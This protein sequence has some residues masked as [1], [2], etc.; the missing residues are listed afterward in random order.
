MSRPAAASS[1][2][3][4][5]A[6]Q[7]WLPAGLVLIALLVAAV[8]SLGAPLITSV[9]ASYDVSL[10]AAQWTLTV[11][12]LSGAVCTPLL[13]RLGT[14]RRR[15]TATLATLTV[16]TA[17]SVGTVLSGPFALLVAGRAA[18]GVG[19]GLVPL[20]M[21]TARDSLDERRATSVIAM[22]SVATTAAIGVGYPLT[23]FLA[24]IGG[25]R[26]AYAAGLVAT[27]AALLV[28]V[29]V[30]P[31]PDAGAGRP[32]RVDWAGAVLLGLALIAVL[33]PLG[34][35][36]LWHRQAAVALLLLGAGV[37][38]LLV[39]L[40]VERRVAAPL[41]DL[42][43]LRHPMV[44]R[45][46]LAM[47]VGGAAMY[48]LLTLATRYVQTPAAAG[49]GF[50]LDTFEAGLVLVPFS[51][52]GFVAGRM[53]PRLV[54]RINAARTVAASLVVVALGFVV[55]VVGRSTVAGPVVA[56][57]VLGLG[58]GAVSAA[59]PA[60][61]LASTPTGQTAGAMS[62]NQVVRSVG[63]AVGSALGG[64]ILSAST[65]AGGFPERS[66]YVAA[67][68]VG[69][70]LALVAAFLVTLGRPTDGAT[71]GRRPRS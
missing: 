23:G 5:T 59:M 46:N 54:G 18:Q 39:W 69:A 63:F 66:G 51:V 36:D 19:L 2:R 71:T 34:D 29:R 67:S 45:A 25:V 55:L 38:L 68:V 35:H 44:A 8:G 49:Y 41:V 32:P 70:L 30:L 50:G 16:V 22:V 7:S 21:A 9:A 62:V 58:V 24:D 65:V 15:R 11:T 12:L 17:G 42:R 53:T 20:L 14:G 28:G 56:V 61:I 52:A 48:L 10:A 3:D 40:L 1:V 60:M 4:E 6:V 37:A 43:A 57:T 13:G 26:T 27:A 47:F 64:L 31:H 33:V